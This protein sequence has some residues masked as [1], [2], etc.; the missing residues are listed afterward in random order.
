MS[1]E[2]KKERKKRNGIIKTCTTISKHLDEFI[3]LSKDIQTKELAIEE[4]EE[5]FELL[6]CHLDSAIVASKA[7]KMAPRLIDDVTTNDEDI[8]EF[9]K[10]CIIYEIL[11]ARINND[12]IKI[13]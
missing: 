13:N 7:M 5:L 8:H 2:V 9:N 6:F 4:Y 10:L 11:D 12:L 3:K 1:K